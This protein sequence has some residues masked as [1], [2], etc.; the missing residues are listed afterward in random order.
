MKIELYT[1]L[2]IQIDAN[3]LI[4]LL[5]LNDP[6]IIEDFKDIL[7]WYKKIVSLKLDLA[8]SNNVNASNV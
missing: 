5:A 3:E 4:W 7:N 1:L 8:N 6:V 2:K